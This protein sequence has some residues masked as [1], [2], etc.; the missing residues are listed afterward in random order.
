LGA[1]G[2]IVGLPGRTIAAVVKKPKTPAERAVAY[3]AVA[4]HDWLN[5]RGLHA[6]LVN[7][8]QLSEVVGVSVKALLE[9]SAEGNKSAGPLGPISALSEHIAHLEVNGPGVVDIGEETW[10]LTVVQIEAAS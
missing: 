4:N 7:T 3:V 9:A 5:K 1:V 2:T 6:S 10:W 8:E